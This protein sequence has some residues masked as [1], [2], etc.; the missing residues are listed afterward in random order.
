MKKIALL[1][2]AGA[3]SW[4]PVNAVGDVAS[5]RVVIESDGWELIGDLR[6]SDQATNV[7]VVLMLNQAAGDRTPYGQLAA[8]LDELSI[9]S[10]RLDL[11]GHGQS[12]NL[13]TF[14]PQELTEEEREA[15]ILSAD[16]DVLA[17]HRFLRSQHALDAS[18]IAIIGATYGGEETD[19]ADRNTTH[20]RAYVAISPGSF[21]GESIERMDES[22]A[23]WLFIV[24][25]NDPYLNDI[26]ANVHKTTT[27]FEILYIP[28]ET[29]TTDLLNNRPDVAA[30]IASW[31]EVALGQPGLAY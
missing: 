2:L 16:R 18:R 7:P 15:M 1:W 17:A 10:L 22:G 20:P 24:A 9:A 29:H 31:L 27:S 19:E 8:E 3:A 30:R 11:R 14:N 28:G 25:E 6:V 12:T 23:A 13:G 21:S 5:E 26:V 4:L